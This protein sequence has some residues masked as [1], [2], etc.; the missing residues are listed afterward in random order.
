[1]GAEYVFDYLI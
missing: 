1:M